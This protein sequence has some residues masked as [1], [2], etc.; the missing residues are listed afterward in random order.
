MIFALTIGLSSCIR[1][2]T[3]DDLLSDYQNDI[4]ARQDIYE[5]YIKLY[6]VLS[7]QTIKSIVKVTKTTT[8]PSFISIG[9]GFIFS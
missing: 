1:E 2:H 6:D 5:N 7:T 9:S 3:Y 4:E 8:S